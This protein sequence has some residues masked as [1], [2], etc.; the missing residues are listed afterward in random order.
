[1]L[2]YR[3]ADIKPGSI[4]P[5]ERQKSYQ[6]LSIE[7]YIVAGVYMLFTLISYFFFYHHPEER[8]L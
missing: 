8:E 2:V 7:C 4:D 5:V 3:L 1:M 6:V